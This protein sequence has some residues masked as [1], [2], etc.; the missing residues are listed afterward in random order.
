MEKSLVFLRICYQIIY[1][2]DG[3]NLHKSERYFLESSSLY[4]SRLEFKILPNI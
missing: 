4:R 3:A 1:S 2:S